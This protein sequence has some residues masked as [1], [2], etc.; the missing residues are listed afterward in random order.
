MDKAAELGIDWWRHD[1][2]LSGQAA[3]RELE[4]ENERLRERLRELEGDQ[5]GVSR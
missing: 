4:D 3:D 1:P 2:M 5:R